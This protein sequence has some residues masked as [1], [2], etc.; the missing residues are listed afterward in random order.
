MFKIAYEMTTQT[1]ISPLTDQVCTILTMWNPI[2]NTI[3]LFNYDAKVRRNIK[4][5]F[6]WGIIKLIRSKALSPSSP[7]GLPPGKVKGGKKN[8]I[9]LVYVDASKKTEELPTIVVESP[10]NVKTVNLDIGDYNERL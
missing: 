4:E 7:T 6:Q 8:Q 10:V 1:A 3:L 9:Q 2:A 5:L